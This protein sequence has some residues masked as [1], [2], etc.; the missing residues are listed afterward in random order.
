MTI[1]FIVGAI[2]GAAAGSVL[3][4]AGDGAVVGGTFGT[5]EGWLAETEYDPLTSSRKNVDPCMKNRG[6]EILSNLGKG[7]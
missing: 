7:A 2:A 3:G 6:Y 1:G 5:L 4:D